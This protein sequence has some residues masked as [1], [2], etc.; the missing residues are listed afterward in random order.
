MDVVDVH[1][2]RVAY[3]RAGRGEPLVLLHGFVGDGRSTWAHQV[4]ALADDCTVIVWDV[5]GAGG[6][7]P[8]PSSF[9]V[10]DYADVLA[11]FLQV[12]GV[13][14]CH[15]AGLSF[16]GTLALALA[17]RAPGVVGSLVLLSAYA[18]WRGSLGADAA[19]ARMRA[20][21]EA[22]RLL[23]AEFGTVMLP[24]MFS[25]GVPASAAAEFRASVEAFDREGFLTMARACEEADLTAVLGAVGAP[26]LVVA[27]DADV[28][29]PLPVA[30]AIR[31]GIPGSRLVVLPGVGHVVTV[32][33]PDAVTREMRAFLAGLPPLG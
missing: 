19:A 22:A 20:C 33:S 29:A 6:S 13:R 17:V 24:S 2:L 28:R 32:E 11:V 25:A 26:T 27:G 4:D 31:A 8:P 1:G 10:D 9:R 7:Q 5:P 21:E 3:E 16:G 23:P 15:V 30:E 12:L 14:R 18:G